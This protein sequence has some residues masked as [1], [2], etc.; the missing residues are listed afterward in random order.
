MGFGTEKVEEE[1]A[2]LFPTARILRLDRDTA[3]SPA[4]YER[5]VADFERGEADVLVGTQ[6]VTKGFD[7]PKLGL[8]GILHADNLLNYPDFRASERA[9]QTM[10]QV[11]GRA[12][13]TDAGGEVVIQTMQP[14]HPVVRQV[15]SFDYEGMV[16]SQLVERSA[17]GYPPYGKLVVVNLRHRDER[18]LGAAAAWVAARMRTLFGERVYGP[19]PPVVDK[20]GGENYLEILLKI[21]NGRSPGA[22][23][24][25]A[26]GDSEGGGRSRGVQARFHLL[27]C[28]PP[29]AALRSVGGCP[30][31]VWDGPCGGISSGTVYPRMRKERYAK[32]RERLFPPAVK[33]F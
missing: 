12:G 5:I 25:V 14:D 19:H 7:F 15:Q 8:V 2:S 21:E 17:F 11:A 32:G 3:A 24:G 20:I 30:C 29:I 4:R 6:M 18:L 23:Q 9:Y 1:V 22:C 31:P 28:G 10:T 27:R 13:R 26:G 33:R 16:R